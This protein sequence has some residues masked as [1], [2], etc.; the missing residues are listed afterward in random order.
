MFKEYYG[1]SEDPFTLVP[2]TRKAICEILLPKAGLDFLGKTPLN[3]LW[4]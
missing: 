3:S 4:N 1:L 2:L